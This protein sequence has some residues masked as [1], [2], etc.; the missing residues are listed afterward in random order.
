MTVEPE[1]PAELLAGAAEFTDTALI[2]ISR[3]SG[4]GWD[5]KS[6]RYEGQVSD[7]GISPNSVRR[8]SRTAISA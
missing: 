8:F 1:V 4:E 6:V 5:R 2:V 3:F 7:E